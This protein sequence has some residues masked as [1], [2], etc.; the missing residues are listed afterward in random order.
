MA[1]GGTHGRY[2]IGD[3]V[4]MSVLANGTITGWLLGSGIIDDR[5]LLEAFLSA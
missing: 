1:I 5:W 4:L 3:T 2:Y